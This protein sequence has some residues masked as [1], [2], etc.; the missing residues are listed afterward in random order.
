MCASYLMPSSLQKRLLRYALS[1]LELVDTEELDLENLDI[2]WGKRSVVELRDVGLRLKKVAS[3]LKFPQ[4]LNLTKANILLLR[5]TFPAD[6][7]HSGIVV[8]VEGVDIQVRAVTKQDSEEPSDQL[9]PGHDRRNSGDQSNSATRSERQPAAHD[10]GGELLDVDSDAESEGELGHLPTTEALANSFLQAEPLPEKAE[11]QAA[12]S[13]QS[14]RL[15]ESMTSDTEDAE[16]VEEEPV[17]GTGTALSLPG[18]LA[19][20]LK[21]VIDRLEIRVKEVNV[22]L[23]VDLRADASSG[24]DGWAQVDH[25]IVQLKVQDV[26]IEGVTSELWD[27]REGGELSGGDGE[28]HKDRATTDKSSPKWKTREG[29]RSI[30]LRN[31]QG[32]LI[33]EAALFESLTRLSAPPSP[34]MTHSSLPKVTE[35]SSSYEDEAETVGRSV[36]HKHTSG[37]SSLGGSSEN[38][39]AQSILLQPSPGMDG[40]SG[41]LEESIATSDGSRFADAGD[42]D[43]IGEIVTHRN[44]LLSSGDLGES[45]LDDSAYL[46][47]VSE[48]RFDDGD[49]EDELLL[50]NP[51]TGPR[52]TGEILLMPATQGEDHKATAQA[53]FLQSSDSIHSGVPSLDEHPASPQPIQ[54]SIQSLENLG[55][56]AGSRSKV[57]IKHSPQYTRLRSERGLAS[58]REGLHESYDSS[59]D[60]EEMRSSAEEDLAESKIFSHEEAES[61]YMSALS[62]ASSIRS[63]PLHMAGGWESSDS[64]GSDAE[65]V[66][67]SQPAHDAVYRTNQSRHGQPPPSLQGSA[68]L[69]QSGTQAERDMT[70]TPERQAASR[71]LESLRSSPAKSHLPLKQRNVL[72]PPPAADEHDEG[73]ESSGKSSSYSR[74]EKRI[75]TADEI[76]LWLP[77]SAAPDPQ[78][79]IVTQ[80][81]E[82]MPRLDAT[83][84]NYLG[85]PGAFSTYAFQSSTVQGNKKSETRAVD[86]PKGRR[87]DSGPRVTAEEKATEL[88]VSSQ[89][90]N[91][92]EIDIGN[93]TGSIDVSVGRIMVKLLQQLLT[94]ASSSPPLCSSKTGDPDILNGPSIKIRAE[95]ISLRFLEHLAALA[96]ASCPSINDTGH[97]QSSVKQSES[98]ILLR[99]TFRGIDLSFFADQGSSTT[100]FSVEKFLFGYAKENI[101]SFDAGLRMRSSTRDILAPVDKDIS[102]SLTQSP[103]SKKLNLT[104]LPLLISLDLQRLDETFSWFGG[105]S[106]I[107]GLGSL[108]ASNATIT[109]VA[110]T[111]SKSPKR[112]R[113]VH[114]EASTLSNPTDISPHAQLK[115]NARLGGI[116]VELIGR[117]CSI[118]LSTTALRLVSREEGLGV[119]VDKARISGP[120]LRNTN[121]E[122][123]VLIDIGNTRVEYLSAPKE[124]DLARLL[125]LLTP[126][127]NKYGQDDDILIDTLIRQRQQG[128]LLRITLAS[129]SGNIASVEDLGVLPSLGEEIAKLSSVTKYLPEDERPGILTLALV[130]DLKFRLTV[131]DNFGELQLAALNLDVAHVSLPSLLA[132]GIGKVQLRRNNLEEL[133][134]EGTPS[135]ASASGTQ[136]LMIMA[137]MIGDELEPTVRIKLWNI[138]A[139]YTVPTALAAIGLSETA[140]AEEAVAD[141]V[142]S[143]ATLTDRGLTREP[144]SRTYN[145]S[146]PSG[147]SNNVSK[148]RVEFF[149][150]DCIVGLNPLDIPSKGLIVLTETHL[151]G[152]IPHNEL[153]EAVLEIHKASL[154]IIDDTQNLLRADEAPISGRH[155]SFDYGSRQVSD[156][157][158]M[159]FVSVSYISSAKAIFKLLNSEVEG[160]K[161]VDLE[162]RDDL[163]VLESCADSTQT[164]LS[165]V[166]G[167]KPPTPPSHD[168]K[169]RTEV[170]PVE[171]MLASLSGDAFA[172]TD[173]N[174]PLGWDE[175]DM[176]DDDVPQNLEFVESFYRPDS[177]PT[178]EEVADGLL[179]DDL[180]QLASLP[181]TRELGSKVLLES[182]REQYSIAPNEPLEFRE[183][184]FGS[185]SGPEGTAHKWNSVK[186]TY[187]TVYQRKIR[188]SPLRVRVRDVHVIW[189][190]F[191]GYDWQKTR[192]TIS[193]AVKEVEVKALERRSRN[194]RRVS[195]D[196][197][198]DEESV[199]GDFLFNSIYIG[200]PANR[201]PRELSSQINR[202]FDD[203]ASETE[204]YATSNISHSPS[205]QGFGSRARGKRLKLDR[206]KHHKIAFELKGVSADLIVFP[207]GTG[208]T[209][210]SLDVR[211]KD[212]EIF[213]HV[214]TS[215]WKKFVTYMHDAGERESGSSMIHL[216]VLN[217]K[218]IP[219]LAASE[220]VVKATILPLRLHVDQDA[221]DF[222][223]RFFEFKDDTIPIHASPADV[224]FLQRVEINAVQVKL[225]YKPKTVDYAGLRSGHTTEFMNFFILDEADMVLR[226]VI[227]YGVSGFDKLSKTLNDVW[228]PD[229][230]QNQLPG[231]LAGLA[232]VRSL[233][234]VGGGV[235]DLVVVPMREYR[236]DGRVV[237]SIQ[238]GA[239]AFAKTTTSE[240][241]KLGAKLAIG[242][243][244]VL[245]GAE[246]FLLNPGQRG[247]S[248]WEDVD[249]D[250]EEKKVISLYADQP[251]GVRQGLRGAYASLERDL[252]TARDAIIAVPGEVMES[253][254]AQGAARAV[255]KR[256]PT[257]ILRPV[258]GASKAISQTLM[259][260]TNSLDPQHRRRIEDKYKKH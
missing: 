121:R 249:I 39:M 6:V 127:K 123:S 95:K 142:E 159:G 197:E 106:S 207:P 30:R 188:G 214:P 29:K 233:V 163:L 258:I 115:A 218:P 151:S 97:E 232:P 228:M 79:D 50:Q 25:V 70:P 138:R 226:H 259:G 254:S 62:Q 9:R 55:A 57:A 198:E 78:S 13:S 194:E 239:L 8:E 75:L 68:V 109:G 162:L 199:I 237:R 33:S 52:P 238:K 203:L 174:S 17:M 26:D 32:I 73:S 143:I 140:T 223:T 51:P 37:L 24:E 27:V 196:V 49:L 248:K 104:T 166:N 64:G 167:L 43:E 116:T 192:D 250:E 126:S 100:L 4:T 135:P 180:G 71:P 90:P 61:M 222:I 243:Q 58:T 202:N 224:P 20:F 77:S 157:C 11:I 205:R 108:T 175:G 10:P 128:P 36:S 171:D 217:V 31:I 23:E 169:Y 111:A 179:E 74:V 5:I 173:G 48:S 252:L 124:A 96:T 46:D 191:D 139:E 201:D 195:F 144:S 22:S 134:G 260:A 209:Q 234:N 99:T 117:D 38:L 107:L 137:R 133:L 16:D 253:G 103:T 240:L 3:L 242:T 98:D 114:F 66:T 53:P 221:L 219:D 257:V 87:R 102:L 76:T 231:V 41:N 112:S 230:K 256:A 213:D 18:F 225:D 130:R 183:N 255:L 165:I 59:E 193:K 176:V 101:L 84:S 122:A 118:N 47:Q 187:S 19:G 145:L 186:N 185:D 129:I 42:E 136:S 251:V 215:T 45:F 54:L 88:A 105:F 119:Q 212:M 44:A 177:E 56:G 28:K 229:I 244:T 63:G 211:V 91:S 131:N 172:P 153:F 40:E 67:T 204:S 227:I 170:V 182:F 206:S 72:Q 156:L 82:T 132:L 190:L 7:Y 85:V 220:I 147:G 247:D 94:V 2:V 178:S 34:D 65:P 164:L 150:Q 200:I 92:M 12:I 15:D 14:R 81:T 86:P 60:S 155:Q 210:S 152:S 216:E 241:V 148:P 208:E 83:E 181:K 110:P 235:R 161:C 80:K 146:T 149:L 113:G 89:D 160:E 189:N 184:H 93:V 158:R 1:R 21:G 141:M 125:S 168:I 154:L 69:S 246:G 35:S 120:H 245:Q 236:K